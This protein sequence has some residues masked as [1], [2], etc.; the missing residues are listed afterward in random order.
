MK[1]L[2]C[3]TGKLLLAGAVLVSALLMA[4]A[5][6]DQDLAAYYEQLQLDEDEC[7]LTRPLEETIGMKFRFTDFTGDGCTAEWEPYT[8]RGR[9]F[10]ESANILINDELR[11]S[12]P[13]TIVI[14]GDYVRVQGLEM[15]VIHTMLNGRTYTYTHTL[16]LNVYRNDTLTWMSGPQ[17]STGD[18][19][20]S[21]LEGDG[22]GQPPE[23]SVSWEAY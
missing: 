1:R 21:V 6:P 7:F 9:N 14:D 19:G 20:V 18:V 15:T 2:L 23:G 16:A 11:G 17:A 22:W 4:G 13:C 5:A 10:K 3:V 8:E 12:A